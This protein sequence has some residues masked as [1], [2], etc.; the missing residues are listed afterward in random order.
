MELLKNLLIKYSSLQTAFKG[1]FLLIVLF[2][3]FFAINLFI[4][5]Q[6]R[7]KSAY[8]VLNKE[9]MV[10]LQDTRVHNWDEIE[11]KN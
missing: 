1:F 6:N 7:P 2:L 11:K 4:S 10:K 5:I 9:S 8:S 3:V